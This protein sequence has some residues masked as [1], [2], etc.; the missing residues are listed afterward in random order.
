[1]NP[2][3]AE[4]DGGDR[5]P[6]RR[7]H[8]GAGYYVRRVL[9]ALASLQLTVVLFALS[10]ALVFLG[11][12]AQVDSGIWTV[13]DKYFW[14][15]VVWVPTDLINKFGQVFIAE[16]FPKGR[17]WPGLF[18]F[19]AGKLLGGL[20]LVNLLAAHATRFRLTWRRS[21]VVLIHGGMIL[22]FAGE[23]VTREYA[24]EQRMTIAEGQSVNFTE[25]HRVVE[26]AF[27][28]RT[29]PKEDRVVVVPESLLRKT[30]ERITD[31]ELPADVKVTDFMPNS[32]LEQVGGGRPNPATAGTG[33]RAVAVRKPEVSGTDPNQKIDVPS[34]YVTLYKKGTAEEIGTYLVSGWL[35]PGSPTAALNAVVVG[36]TPH[37]VALRFKRYYK[38]YS[39][40]LVKFRFD[41]YAGTT[42]AKN[43]SSDVRLS[44]PDLQ[45][46]D[47]P[48]LIRMNEPM[49]HRGETFYQQSFDATETGTVLQVVKNPGWL[50]PYVSC[51]VVTFG[52]VV[53][54]GITLTKFLV[55]RAAA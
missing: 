1:M 31:A 53:H 41:R 24:V 17:T 33:L 8:P 51:V 44:D 30:G 39:I 47:E 20:M 21:G 49:R 40:A 22:L 7:P 50:I 6:P 38:P 16:W 36:G 23:F 26:L 13:V 9:K 45:V 27:V 28:D 37:G 29:D 48:H 52:L 43:Y 54:F 3:T 34:A 32:D 42:K 55:R 25:D 18:P 12:L 35:A 14:S 15:W 46:A 2:S 4:P 19:P 11:T 10:I 5:P